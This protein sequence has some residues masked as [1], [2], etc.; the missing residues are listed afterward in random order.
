[1]SF[2]QGTQRLSARE[3]W[4]M[5]IIRKPRETTWR[6]ELFRIQRSQSRPQWDGRK[7]SHG[8]GARGRSKKISQQSEKASHQ[9]VKQEAISCNPKGR[10]WIAHKHTRRYLPLSGKRK[11][12]SKYKMKQLFLYPTA[13]LKISSRNTQDHQG[14]CCWGED[15]EERPGVSWQ[16]RRRRR[17]GR[18]L[19]RL[20]GRVLRVKCTAT[21]WSNNF[22]PLEIFYPKEIKRY[23]HRKPCSIMFC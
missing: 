20:L 6:Q 22:F 11:I 21:L 5:E 8:A 19:W 13:L 1:M 12:Q 15:W 10:F 2:S 17:T 14:L 23:V 4:G 9:H 3:N 18:P 7:R 16:W